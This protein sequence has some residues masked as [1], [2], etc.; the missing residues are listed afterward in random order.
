MIHS[1]TL[2]RH[3]AYYTGHN[4]FANAVETLGVTSKREAAL[5]ERAGGVLVESYLAA[6]D[7]ADKVNHPPGGDW[8][9]PAARGEFSDVFLHG[10]AIY[11]PVREVVG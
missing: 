10:L 5:V 1:Y 2:V 11:I 6:E 8:L 4:E 3:S 7:L 9:I